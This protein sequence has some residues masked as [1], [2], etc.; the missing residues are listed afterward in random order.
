MVSPYSNMIQ[1]IIDT[2]YVSSS[3]F[4]FFFFCCCCRP[5]KSKEI[6]VSS[7]EIW[8]GSFPN[9]SKALGDHVGK[10]LSK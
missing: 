2:V 9:K 5:I 3:L 1:T 10:V 7:C 4:F 6:G 8:L